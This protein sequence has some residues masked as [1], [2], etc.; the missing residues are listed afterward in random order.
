MS[1]CDLDLYIGSN[2]RDIALETTVQTVNND[3]NDNKAQLGNDDSAER[4]DMVNGKFLV[5]RNE[6]WHAAF[7]LPKLT[8]IDPDVQDYRYIEGN[9]YQSNQLDAVKDSLIITVKAYDATGEEIDLNRIWRLHFLDEQLSIE[10]SLNC[11]LATTKPMTGKF[12]L[13]LSIILG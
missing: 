6:D 7:N 2:D 4:L 9:I 13:F 11:L 1:H 8:S 5:E 12:C 3:M 10:L